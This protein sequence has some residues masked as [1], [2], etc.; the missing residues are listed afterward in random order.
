MNKILT[1]LL[2]ISSITCFGQTDSRISQIRSL[3]K[4]Y[5]ENLSD[6]DTYEIKLN[7][8]GSF[9][10]MIIYTDFGNKLLFITDDGDEFG[11]SSTEYY[12]LNDTIQFIFS[13]SERL[14]TH[15]S[16]DTVRYE[17]LELRFYFENGK[18]IKALKKQLH[19]DEGQE[20]ADFS[21]IPN[22]TIDYKNEEESNWSYYEGKVADLMR[23]YNELERVF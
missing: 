11:S 3:Y 17:M 1:I 6:M 22:Q 2:F 8:A 14:I 16:A 13:K 23:F 12:F 10:S 19:G 5:N 15:W 9:P 4:D 7:T 18:V 20:R 21:S